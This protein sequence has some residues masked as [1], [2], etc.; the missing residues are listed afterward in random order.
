MSSL[1][2]RVAERG[3]AA[4]PLHAQAFIQ[5]VDQLGRRLE[6]LGDHADPVLAEVFGV[7]AEGRRERL[8]H[9]V[10]GHR[11]ISVD[12]VVQVAGR[13]LRLVRERTVGETGLV[14]QPLHGRAEGLLAEP[15]LP[16]HYRSLTSTRLSSPVARSRTSTA[17]SSRLFFPAVMR[18]GMPIRSASA[19]FSPALASRSSSRLS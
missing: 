3:R 10:R 1:T 12:E 17:P 6:L 19:N 5:T 2:P 18:T 14:H 11:A 13:E 15:P 8:H 7:D 9:V 4:S 16:G